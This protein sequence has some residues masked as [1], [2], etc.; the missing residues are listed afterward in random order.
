MWPELAT[1]NESEAH[2]HGS[3]RSSKP[4]KPSLPASCPRLRHSPARFV[5]RELSWLQFNRRVMEEAS[6][7]N[8][9][10]LEQ[11]R[12]LSISAN[13]LDEFFMVR[14]SGL[15]EQLKAG[16]VTPSQD[17]LTPAEQLAE[18]GKAVLG[19]DRRPAGAL[20]RA[21]A[22]SAREPHPS[23]SAPSDIGP[24]ERVWLEDYFLNYVFPVLTPLA[25]DPAH[26]FP[27]IPNLG[28][29]LALALERITRRA[30]ARRAD[31]RA[32]SRWTASSNCPTWRAT[33]CIASS[34]WRTRSRCS[35]A[36]CSRATTSRAPA[37]SASS[38]T[39]TSTSRRRP[40]IWCASSRRC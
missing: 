2:E 23:C 37:R 22:R 18:L 8:H 34:R 33:A 4:L 31:P 13:N 35:S 38:A 16:V 6:N 36:S 29:T 12:F 10:L 39:P 3:Q 11:L 25:I 32:R 15:R 7:R 40:R 30:P 27:F 17:G 1:A 28:F 14:V 19:A 20:G 26:P 24:Q 9:P 5:N 21:Q